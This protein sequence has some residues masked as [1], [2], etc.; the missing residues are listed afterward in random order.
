[1]QTKLQSF[2]EAALNIAIGLIVALVTQLVVFPWFGVYIPLRDDLLIVG[3]FT[4]VSIVRSYV[5]RRFFNWYH[6]PG[7][8]MKCVRKKI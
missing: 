7:G 4:A 3:I 5:L 8:I 2:L 6:A 1:M